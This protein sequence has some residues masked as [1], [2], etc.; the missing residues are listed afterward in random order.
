MASLDRGMGSGA[1]AGSLMEMLVQE[2][3][4]PGEMLESAEHREFI[5]HLVDEL[6][7]QL[8]QVVLLV[9]YQGLKYREAADALAIP[10][11]TV[12]SRL[13]AAIQKLNE[14]LT[15]DCLSA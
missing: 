11:G 7:E 15:V 3:P 9:Y 14:L 1:E 10:V 13:H 12:K 6:P 2:S 8:K 4:T 5:R